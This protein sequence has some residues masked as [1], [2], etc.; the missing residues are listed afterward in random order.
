M[1]ESQTKILLTGDDLLNMS[2]EA[3]EGYELIEGELVKMVPTGLEHGNVEN[4]AAFQLT[5]FNKQHKLGRILTGEI[6][7]YIH[8]HDRTV[9]A[10]D[11]VFISYEHLPKDASFEGYSHIAPDLVVEVIS[12]GNT[13]AEMEQKIREWFEFGV[14]L[15]WVIYPK[16]QRVHV[17]TTSDKP[18]ILDA[19]AHIDG[20]D[21]LPGFSIPIATFFED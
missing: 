6:G 8:G 14:R 2:E 13:A 18:T 12:P 17:Y 20:G 5:L 11:V 10:A 1:V 21:V 9:R 4:G 15:V 7:F 3:T 16:T 19:D